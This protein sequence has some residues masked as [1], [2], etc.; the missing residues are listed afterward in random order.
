MRLFSGESQEDRYSK[1]LQSVVENVPAE[2]LKQVRGN[3]TYIGTQS[4]RKGAASYVL[5]QL[6]GLDVIAV[7]FALLLEPWKCA[8]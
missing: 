8:G 4:T 3:A 6:G 5:S 7:F 1:I 2:I